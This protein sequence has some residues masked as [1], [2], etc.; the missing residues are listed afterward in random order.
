MGMELVGL[1]A[2]VA[3]CG[4]SLV[5][6]LR[7][8]LLARRTRELPERLIGSAFLVGGAFG[9]P[10][11]IAS[12]LIRPA[13]PQLSHGLFYLASLGLV[14]AAICLLLFWQRVYRGG[15]PGAR[16]VVALGALTLV[17]A[18][19]GLWFTHEAGTAPAGSPWFLPEIAAQGVAYA[20]NAG[21]S[22][23][24]WLRL[25]RR[26]VLN[27]ADPAVVERIGLWSVAAWAVTFQY[28]YTLVR[29][30]LTGEALLRG[31]EAALLTSIGLVAAASIG[32]AFFP[33]AFQ[34]R[35]GDLVEHTG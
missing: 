34:R 27:L 31:A 16:I 24:L 22:A 28:A 15:Q 7:L 12:G 1:L 3:Y 5:V 8:L 32:R 14:V 21:A 29:T 2:I 9:Y 30:W 33:G 19:I 25:R 26:L 17:G 6:G 35:S 11:A 23:R 20:V 4:V 18:L 10:T 13:A